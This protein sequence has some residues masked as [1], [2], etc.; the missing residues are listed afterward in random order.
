[1]QNSHIPKLSE[2]PRSNIHYTTEKQ[3]S[4]NRLILHSAKNTFLRLIN[5][6]D[7]LSHRN[8]NVP[9]P[10]EIIKKDL[11]AFFGVPSDALLWFIQGVLSILAPGERNHFQRWHADTNRIYVGAENTLLKFMLAPCVWKLAGNSPLISVS[12]ERAFVNCR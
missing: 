12:S 4:Q 7:F 1:M 10:R 2:R 3:F 6:R 9:F 8:A 5:S 11:K